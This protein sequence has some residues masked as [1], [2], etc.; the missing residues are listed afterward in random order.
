MAEVPKVSDEQYQLAGFAT[1][2][3]S[4]LPGYAEWVSKKL[5]EGE[6][7]EDLERATGGQVMISSEIA[8]GDCTLKFDQMLGMQ[9]W[10]DM[11]LHEKRDDL[12]RRHPKPR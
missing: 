3:I 6:S 8:S 2:R 10:G 12:L 4:D 5:D 9:R 11:S 1:C 7:I